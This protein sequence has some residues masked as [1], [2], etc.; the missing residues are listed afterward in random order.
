VYFISQTGTSLYR[1]VKIQNIHI[2][3][4]GEPLIEDSPVSMQLRLL[5]SGCLRFGRL[6]NQIE[7][8]THDLKGFQRAVKMFT[9]V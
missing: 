5:L 2:N 9:P 6:G 1:K 8:F 4:K 3:K 7:S